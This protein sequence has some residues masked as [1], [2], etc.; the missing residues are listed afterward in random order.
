MSYGLPENESRA[1]G[2]CT[3]RVIA[4]QRGL[5]RIAT[6]E[7]ERMAG[8]SGRLRHEA[9]SPSDYP[10][11]G[12]FVLAD[13]QTGGDAVIRSVLP[14]RSSFVRRAA[15][16]SHQEQVVAANV[17]TVFLCM[18]L[19]RDFSLR[20][21][22]RDLAVAW[23]SGASPVVVLTKADL[24]ADTRRYA[25]EAERVAVGVPVLVTAS[26]AEDGLDA[27]APYLR[28]GR[29]VAFIG[30]SGVGK[31]TMINRLLGEARQTTGGLRGDDRGRHTT[32][33]REIFQLPGG[34]LRKALA[35]IGVPIHGQAIAG[36]LHGVPRQQHAAAVVHPLPRRISRRRENALAQSLRTKHLQTKR[37]RQIQPGQQCLLRLQGKL[38]GHDDQLIPL[39]FRHG[40]GNTMAQRILQAVT[41]PRHDP[42]HL[43]KSS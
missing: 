2:L 6:A 18:S 39:G 21:L 25:L 1:D 29:T 27:L 12:D 5:Y 17:D 42:Q 20:R 9:L 8:V 34:A 10:A 4:Q 26:L 28:S 16:D 43:R 19:N 38:F 23:E 30:S 33:S 32:T 7:G 13:T 11:V 40:P 3:G 35:L 14:R 41:P 24:C 22:E 36:I 37:A 15:G 31:S